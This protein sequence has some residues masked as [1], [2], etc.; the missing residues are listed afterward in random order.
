METKRFKKFAGKLAALV[1][2]TGIAINS[3]FHGSFLANAASNENRNWWV[4][5]EA[6]SS[7]ITEFVDREWENGKRTSIRDFKDYAL[8]V[9]K[10]EIALRDHG[11]NAKIKPNSTISQEEFEALNGK[12]TG[13]VGDFDYVVVMPSTN[14]YL[15][16]EAFNN[17]VNQSYLFEIKKAS[18]KL[19]INSEDYLDF[20]AIIDGLESNT[21]G[22]SDFLCVYKMSS[23][24]KKVFDFAQNNVLNAI[25]DNEKIQKY[26]R[27]GYKCYTFPSLSYPE[28]TFLQ[29]EAKSKNLTDISITSGPI[30]LTLMKKDDNNYKFYFSVYTRILLINP[31]TGDVQYSNCT[32]SY[33]LEQTSELINLL[34][35]FPGVEAFLESNNLEIVD[36]R[37]VA[38]Y[39]SMTIGGADCS[40]L[41][42]N[43]C[44]IVD[45]LDKASTRS[46]LVNPNMYE[47]DSQYFYNDQLGRD[48][49]NIDELLTK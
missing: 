1:A 29:K 38:Q 15:I 21:I 24:D 28:L 42:S 34:A 8:N 11:A 2:G 37:N 10:F 22:A 16:L 41:V 49:N 14:S 6:D 40:K 48:V 9:A 7:A 44:N 12:L 43:Y 45:Q 25:N 39:I 19:N 26:V 31:K 47:G 4:S 17:G 20:S 27:D 3:I 32:T 33:N 13:L 5:P 36:Q 35:S 46:I 23:S 18:Q 30:A